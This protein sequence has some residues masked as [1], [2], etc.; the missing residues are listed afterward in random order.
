MG[1]YR[2]GKTYWFNVKFQRKRIQGTLET[3]D[4][5]LA[6]KVYE[7]VLGEIVEGTYFEKNRIRTTTI[8]EMIEKYLSEH[9]KSRDHRTSGYLLKHFSGIKLSQI[10][11]PEIQQYRNKRLKKVKPATLYQELAF[12]RRMF[13][14]AIREWEWLSDN[15]VSRLSFGVGN[16]NARTRW[17][18]DEEEKRLL[19]IADKPYWLRSL[20]VFALHTGM[21]K[22][23]ILNLKWKDVDLKRKVLTVVKSKNDALRTLP[24][25][26][27]LF[28]ELCI[29]RSLKVRD[30]SG[31][32]FPVSYNSLRHSFDNA[33]KDAEIVD[34]RFHDLRHTFASKLVQNGVD[35]YRVKELLGHKS[36][37]MTMRYAHLYP[38]SLRSSVDVLCTKKA[39]AQG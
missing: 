27:T 19:E 10:T 17:L 9:A 5:R 34:F 8:D 14:V 24:V 12:M 20:I 25:N 39:Y 22:S 33:V 6:E 30:F 36:I 1:I 32:V 7:K 11:T 2:R 18:S 37:Q 21:R 28:D 13:N 4:K 31:H 26:E 16:K 35:L 3:N 38:E 15:P 29:I 23:E